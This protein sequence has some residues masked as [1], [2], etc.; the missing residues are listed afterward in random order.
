M[1]SVGR[2]GTRLPWERE[3]PIL[4]A[5]ARAYAAADALDSDLTV[6]YLRP[7]PFPVTHAALSR[8][9]IVV[10]EGLGKG[11]GLQSEVS[12]ASEAIE[13][14]FLSTA[15]QVGRHSTLVTA[16]AREIAAQ[17]QVH[18]DRLLRYLESLN[19]RAAVGCGVYQSLTA[20]S[21]S[22]LIPL[23]IV[24]PTYATHPLP[25]DDLAYRQLLR[26]GSSNGSA[27]GTTLTESLL[28]GLLECVE[29]DAVSRFFL[30]RYRADNDRRVRVLLPE[31][32]P[33]ELHRL[34]TTVEAQTQ[35]SV[36]IIDVTTELGIP[37]YLA[38]LRTQAHP[39]G[40][41][42]AGCS[43]DAPYAIERALTELLQ[44]LY[45]PDQAYVNVNRRLIEATR[46]WPSLAPLATPL[47][48]C[49]A[50]DVN[51]RLPSA[52][53]T[54]VQA[55]LITLVNAVTAKGLTPVFRITS[56]PDLPVTTANVYLSGS[57][58]FLHARLG[59]MVAPTGLDYG[60]G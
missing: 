21:S 25:G 35:G 15:N 7:G 9:G 44:K 47:D 17:P 13:H 51:E 48:E 28:H 43:I 31:L 55:S 26:Y 18:D 8:T 60:E 3:T 20:P 58:R 59:I 2:I 39:F 5:R 30:Q 10:S 29:R 33:S 16:A 56:S 57:E 46:R 54:T 12:A 42:G 45:D 41:F 50:V 22:I 1:P 40:I 24:D 37:S 19:P 36:L 6:N 4:E 23:F 14:Y 11:R 53:T 52:A 38:N 32:L 27:A 49:D 34:M